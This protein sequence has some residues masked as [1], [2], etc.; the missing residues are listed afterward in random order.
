MGVNAPV[1]EENGNHSKNPPIKMIPKKLSTIIRTGAIPFVFLLRRRPNK[2][3]M[4]HTPSR[5][6]FCL[7]YDT[8]ALGKKQ[9]EKNNG[10]SNRF[11]TIKKQK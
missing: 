11:I 3:S 7:S 9:E 5:E 6:S 10:F 4:R 1:R 2:S 8:A